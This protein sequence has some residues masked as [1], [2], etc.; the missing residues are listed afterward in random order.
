MSYRDLAPAV[1]LCFSALL[2]IFLS[3]S[4]WALRGCTGTV[5][6]IVAAT[7]VFAAA[8]THMIITADVIGAATGLAPDDVTALFAG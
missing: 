7:A 2:V 8:A 1:L 4:A 6:A 5:T 3:A